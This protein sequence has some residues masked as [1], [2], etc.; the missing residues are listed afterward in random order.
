MFCVNTLFLHKKHY[1]SVEINLV[2][3]SYFRVSTQLPLYPSN[4]VNGSFTAEFNNKLDESADAF[5]SRVILPL[6]AAI[7][8]KYKV[9]FS[10]SQFSEY[11]YFVDV[12]LEDNDDAAK[13]VSV[14]Q[15]AIPDKSFYFFWKP[16]QA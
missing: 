7:S 1:L 6:N 16:F 11:N 3:M 8:K 4:V 2:F 5:R 14:I 10:P 13:V 9:I 12:F 15:N